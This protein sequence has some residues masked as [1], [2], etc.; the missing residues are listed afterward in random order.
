MKRALLCLPILCL[1]PLGQ[2]LG[3]YLQGAGILPGAVGSMVIVGSML[4]L[5]LGVAAWFA[6]APKSKLWVHLAR[7]YAALALPWCLTF[8]FLPPGA[9]CE[10]MGISHRLSQEFSSDE[11]RECAAHLRQ[12]R[13]N[14]TLILVDHKGVSF[15]PMSES[16]LLVADSDL[17][18]SLRGRFHCVFIQEDQKIMG[19][20][21]F[22]ALGK[23]NGIVCD[24]RKYVRELFICSMADGV[25]AYRYERL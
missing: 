8:A 7:F 25:H 23:Y 18:E 17:P 24:G 11:L 20:Q 2:F 15:F 1:A 4:V 5:P 21:V 3:M 13:H 14:G 19:E 22:F 10:M 9:I 16:A 12:K 6:A